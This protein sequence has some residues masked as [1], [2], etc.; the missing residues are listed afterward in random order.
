[1]QFFSL[2]GSQYFSFMG[3]INIRSGELIISPRLQYSASLKATNTYWILGFLTRLHIWRKHRAKV[4]WKPINLIAGE[5]I[6]WSYHGM[7]H[8][9]L[10]VAHTQFISFRHPLFLLTCT[11]L[12]SMSRAVN[13]SVRDLYPPGSL[14]SLSVVYGSM[15][16]SGSELQLTGLWSSPAA[17][18][19]RLPTSDTQ[20]LHE[21]KQQQGSHDRSW[22][23]PLFV[24][25][26]F[27]RT[28][29]LTSWKEINSNTHT[30]YS[31]EVRR[32]P[33]PTCDASG[34]Q[35][36]PQPYQ[37]PWLQL[38]WLVLSRTVPGTHS[39]LSLEQNTRNTCCW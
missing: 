36:F 23:L 19:D 11:L 7:I 37:T 21:K 6:K 38:E 1:M 20:S 35:R 30:A 2:W 13:G 10:K 25:K 15:E 18:M 22:Q 34:S 14:L 28:E 16:S 8:A 31:K 5:L 32:T 39:H 4:K 12:K 9:E 3:P 17:D 29:N 24:S 27:P 26:Q 33:G